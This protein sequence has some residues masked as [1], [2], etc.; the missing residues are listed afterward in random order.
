M[1]SYYLRNTPVW[2]IFW[3]YVIAVSIPL[4]F[5]MGYLLVLADTTEIAKTRMYSHAA[6]VVL[7]GILAVYLFQVFEG[8][9]RASSTD[10]VPG[11][12]SYCAMLVT[13][14]MLFA[15]LHFAYDPW[16]YKFMVLDGLSRIPPSTELLADVEAVQSNLPRPLAKN[17][18]VNSAMLDKR[19]LV[20][21]VTAKGIVGDAGAKAAE[22]KLWELLTNDDNVCQELVPAFEHGLWIATYEV[23]FDDS[24]FYARITPEKCA[25]GYAHDVLKVKK[26][27]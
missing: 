17:M 5:C 10:R 14:S 26:R 8:I 27:F 6:R 16:R 13:V 11:L 2:R 3:I 4:I 22:E 23:R 19:Q 7:A 18:D 12:W 24:T 9:R 25:E 1:L 15:S 21:D 20:F